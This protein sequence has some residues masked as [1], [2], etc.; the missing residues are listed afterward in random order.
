MRQPKIT[1]SSVFNDGKGILRP[2][3]DYTY[4]WEQFSTAQWTHV[5]SLIALPVSSENSLDWRVM[6]TFSNT[7]NYHI[8]WCF[9]CCCSFV[10]LWVLLLSPHLFLSPVLSPPLAVNLFGH[11]SR[12]WPKKAPFKP[13]VVVVAV[14][15]VV[16]GLFTAQHKSA[17]KTWRRCLQPW[18]HDRSV[19]KMLLNKMQVQKRRN[20]SFLF[21]WPLSLVF[22]VYTWFHFCFLWTHRRCTQTI[23][24]A[25]THIHTH[26]GPGQE[27]D[28][29]D[30]D[31]DGIDGCACILGFIAYLIAAQV[32]H[33]HMTRQMKRSRSEICKTIKQ[34]NKTTTGIPLLD[35]LPIPRFCLTYSNFT[36]EKIEAHWKPLAIIQWP[37][38]CAGVARLS[39]AC[40]AGNFPVLWGN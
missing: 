34:I 23:L 16:S 32:V 1:H 5:L 12:P 4:Y 13:F 28:D 20:F 35:P 26:N 25:H 17:P 3:L 31:D 40:K 24:N 19:R 7:V 21:F 11:C 15:A 8:K 30:G 33:I 18:G 36:H 29:G 27:E 10:A 39:A 22:L 38:D 14:V 6:R 2:N 9:L 37:L